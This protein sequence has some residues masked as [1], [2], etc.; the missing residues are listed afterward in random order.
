MIERGLRW[1]DIGSRSFT[2]DD[3]HA[4]ISTLPFD[5]PLARAQGPDWIWYHPLADL[6]AG[7]YDNTGVIGATQDR[8]PR[9]KKSEIPKQLVR[10]WMKQEH[11]DKI[12]NTP[13]PLDELNK[14]LGW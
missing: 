12:G 1:R 6:V 9:I 4:V 7:I 5:A 8:R 10:P 13:R 11:V 3:C 2:W 14:L